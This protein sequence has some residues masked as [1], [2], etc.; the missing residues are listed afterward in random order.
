MCTLTLYNLG[1]YYQRAYDVIHDKGKIFSIHTR[2][3]YPSSNYSFGAWCLHRCVCQCWGEWG[4]RINGLFSSTS[5]TRISTSLAEQFLN[6]FFPFL[7]AL[8]KP[9]AMLSKLSVHLLRS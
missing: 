9:S 1:I 6:S 3:R 2:H 4:T 8:I 5:S 7:I